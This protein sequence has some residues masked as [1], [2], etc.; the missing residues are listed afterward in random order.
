MISKN[1]KPVMRIFAVL[2]G[3]SGLTMFTFF[4]PIIAFSGMPDITP[5]LYPRVA[6]AFMIG[7]AVIAWTVSND[8]LGRRDIIPGIIISGALGSVV[9]FAQVYIS[10]IA[11]PALG[12]FSIPLSQIVMLALL[13]IM[14][15]YWWNTRSNAKQD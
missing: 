3:L 6:G 12:A 4:R 8:P 1:I 10:Q 13:A 15:L 7:L 2:V 9:V 5:T 11:V 14:G